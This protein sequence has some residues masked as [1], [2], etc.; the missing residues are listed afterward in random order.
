MERHPVALRLRSMYS[1]S[2]LPVFGTFGDA[3]GCE[4]HD[5]EPGDEAFEVGASPFNMLRP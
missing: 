1:A 5:S 3:G 4:K 2:G